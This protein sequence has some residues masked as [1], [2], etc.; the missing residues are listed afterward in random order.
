MKNNKIN[1][2]KEKEII[3]KKTLKSVYSNI[4]DNEDFMP[5]KKRH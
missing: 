2:N 5:K 4:N 1:S 3:K